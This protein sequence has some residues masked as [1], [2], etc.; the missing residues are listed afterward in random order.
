MATSSIP[1]V[2]GALLE[3]LSAALPD[4]QVTWS[5]PTDGPGPEWVRIGNVI[6]DQDAAALGRQ[7]REE[8][9]RVEVL[10]SVVRPEIEEPQEVAERAFAILAEIEDDVRADETLGIDLPGAAQFVW[11]R[12]EKTDLVEGLGGGERWAEVTVHVACVA[13]I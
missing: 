8:R 9:Y 13:R 2:K 4:V 10:V 12:I 6:G 3:H 11:A 7:R 1:T 5:T